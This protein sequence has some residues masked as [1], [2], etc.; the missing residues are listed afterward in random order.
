[1]RPCVLTF[2]CDRVVWNLK[3]PAFAHDDGDAA[4]TVP[5]LLLCI[6]ILYIC[7]LYI[8]IYSW[9]EVYTG[10]FA[11]WTD[12]SQ[13]RTLFRFNMALFVK[14]R[15]CGV[16]TDATDL[17]WSLL[18]LRKHIIIS[19]VTTLSLRALLSSPLFFSVFSLCLLFVFS[20]VSCSMCCLSSL[21]VFLEQIYSDTRASTHP[22]QV[23]KVSR[24]LGVCG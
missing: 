16:C 1:M 17:S 12:L 5:L 14:Y 9:M 13:H 22:C 8:Y 10:C 7:D 24:P 15:L 18:N 4:A 20:S 2:D 21:P 3:W 23:S 6:Y 11:S 19:C